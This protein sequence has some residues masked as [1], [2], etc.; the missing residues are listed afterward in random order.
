MLLVVVENK[1]K[2]TCTHG[3]LHKQRRLCACSWTRMPSIGVT[4]NNV[5]LTKGN[6]PEK[7]TL[8]LNIFQHT[9]QK[10]HIEAPELQSPMTTHNILLI[11]KKKKINTFLLLLLKCISQSVLLQSTRCVN[12]DYEK[13]NQN[14]W[15]VNAIA[16]S[17]PIMQL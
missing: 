8:I 2:H 10:H 12:E 6:I 17:I 7:L 4:L 1:G 9:Q 13:I 5:A 3:Y 15:W 14:W 11:T 16:V